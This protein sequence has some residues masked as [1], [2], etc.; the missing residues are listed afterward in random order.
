M[1]DQD[2]PC[3]LPHRH[4]PDRPR[5]TADGLL[6][7][8]GCLHR[9]EQTLAEMPAKYDALARRLAPTGGHGPHVSGT[10]ER[11]LPI[12]STVADHRKD[13]VGKLASWAVTV[14]EKRGIH[15][16]ASPRPSGTATWLLVHLRWMAAQPWIDEFVRELTELHSRTRSL[17][18]PTGRRRVD[19]GACVEPECDGRLTAMLAPVDDLLPSA[20]TCDRD[21]EH[22]WAPGTWL[23]L[24]RKLHGAATF[25]A[26]MATEFLLMIES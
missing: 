23:S 7:C 2:F 26:R 18:D 20:I 21:A 17:L 16:P 19:V 9:L 11:R 8:L 10:P 12:D 6:V 24:G 25:D 1:T 14:A 5:R 13:I 22:T 4:D 15:T 3:V